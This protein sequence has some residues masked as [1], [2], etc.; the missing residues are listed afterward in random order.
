MHKWNFRPVDSRSLIASEKRTDGINEK[1]LHELVRTL[2]K[3]LP[4]HRNSKSDRIVTALGCCKKMHEKTMLPHSS[5][6]S[7]ALVTLC[8]ELGA[9]IKSRAGR[10]A[11]EDLLRKCELE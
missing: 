4:D 1:K 3:K 5:R 6:T 7:V 8:Q 11:S 2:A 10:G 9:N